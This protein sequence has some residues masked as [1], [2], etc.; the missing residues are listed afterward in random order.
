MSRMSRTRLSSRTSR[1][2][3]TTEA[4]FDYVQGKS[5]SEKISKLFLFFLLS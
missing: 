2:T 1:K 3:F 5:D 4:P